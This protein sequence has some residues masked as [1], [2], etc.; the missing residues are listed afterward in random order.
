[1]AKAISRY[2]PSFLIPHAPH[3]TLEIEV[4]VEGR[5]R[6]NPADDPQVH[7]ES[8]CL[9]FDS[10]GYRGQFD[11]SA[12]KADLHFSSLNP[13]RELDL[14]LR[15][16]GS[17]WAAQQGGVQLHCAAIAHQE[18][19]YI[20]FGHSGAGKTTSARLSVDKTLLSDDLNILLPSNGHWQ[21]HATP[22]W[23]PTQVR[24][25]NTSAPIAGIYRLVQA[26]H[27]N[28]EEMDAVHAL[29]ELISC[30]PVL[31]IAP[32][33]LPELTANLQQLIH[34]CPAYWLEFLPDAGFWQVIT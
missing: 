8:S 33:I 18:Q 10:P 24:P 2:Y 5:Q 21:A 16:A 11:L 4:S 25:N 27:H 7:F 12:G 17:L 28:R 31:K 32:H 29:A 13:F 22:F 14:F 30:I 1:M 3:P 23:N 26:P 9:H 15:I 34:N 6:I 19:A 20:F